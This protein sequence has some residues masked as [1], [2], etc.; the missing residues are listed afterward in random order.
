MNGLLPIIRR[1]RRPLFPPEDAVPVITPAVV[2]L[3]L[4]APPVEAI[5][6]AP[7]EVPTAPPA[8]AKPKK[9]K[10]SANAPA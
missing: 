7:V 8:A 9:A 5:A 6:S 4:S 10:R 3:P 1:A 2:E